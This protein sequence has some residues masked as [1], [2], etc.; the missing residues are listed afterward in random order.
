MTDLHINYPGK[1]KW[2][3]AV[4]ERVNRLSPHIVALTGDLGDRPAA[5]LRNDVAPLSGL[6]AKYGCFFV[7][8]NHE[9]YSGVKEW[10]SETKGLGFT[11]LINEREIVRQGKGRLLLGG[12]TDF[13]AG[14][15]FSKHV[16]ALKRL[17][18]ALRKP[19]S[20]SSLR[21]S[22][23]ISLKLRRLALISSSPVIPMAVSFCPGNMRSV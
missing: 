13:S 1:G 8:G 4:V 2:V 12:V 14:R 16:Q 23:R 7:T 19:I 15:R 18:P 11:A 6:S 5:S 3:K 22:R 17:L 9:Y 10:I 21:I 20:R